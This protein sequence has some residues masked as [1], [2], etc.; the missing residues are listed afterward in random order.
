MRRG[1]G[2]EGREGKKGVVRI[3]MYILIS[4]Q[5]DNMGR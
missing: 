1:Y 5:R 4:M 3:G 2:D